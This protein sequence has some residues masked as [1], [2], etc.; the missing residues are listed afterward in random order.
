MRIKASITLS[1]ATGRDE[2]DYIR[3]VVRDD[4][5]RQ[6]F[7]EIEMTM[8][9]FA[10]AITGLAHQTVPC[11]VR[12]LEFVGLQKV[13]ERRHAVYPESLPQHNRDTQEAWL[14]ENKQEE[15]WFVD[16]S[17]RSQGSVTGSPTTLHYSVYKYLKPEQL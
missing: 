14:R 2:G 17:L 16:A 9:E 12:G 6:A 13:V 4:A 15:G 11:E 7:V 8:E 1:K 5:S 3:L 10:L